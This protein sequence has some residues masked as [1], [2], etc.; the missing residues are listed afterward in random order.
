[1]QMLLFLTY[2]SIA[3]SIGKPGNI[4]CFGYILGVRY[5]DVSEKE[6]G[7]VPRSLDLKCESFFKESGIIGPIAE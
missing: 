1:M 5:A 2:E 7:I 3:R 6:L 4:V